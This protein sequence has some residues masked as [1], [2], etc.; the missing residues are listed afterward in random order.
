MNG[1]APTKAMNRS[2]TQNFIADENQHDEFFFLFA[3]SLFQ[4]RC[5]CCLHRLT[6]NYTLGQCVLCTPCG[7]I[8]LM[9]VRQARLHLH[10]MI[11]SW[12]DGHFVADMQA[13]AA[14]MSHRWLCD[15][16]FSISH[17]PFPQRVPV[18]LCARCECD[19][20]QPLVNWLTLANVQSKVIVFIRL[21]GIRAVCPCAQ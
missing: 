17:F 11:M 1:M 21:N 16:P 7:W 3:S 10:A 5:C 2:T 15:F 12:L 13:I 20:C 4:F 18:V 6:F 8:G 14:V 19:H 9:V